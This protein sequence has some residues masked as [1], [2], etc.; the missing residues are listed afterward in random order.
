MILLE[1][2]KNMKKQTMTQAQKKFRK[3]FEIAEDQQGYFTTKQAEKVGYLPTNFTY[4][5]RSG[6]WIKEGWGIYRLRNFPSSQEDH[7]TRLSL[8]SRNR[9]DVPQGVISHLTALS[10]HEISDANPSKVHMTVPNS[11]RRSAETPVELVLFYSDLEPKDV[12]KRLGYKITTPLKTLI[13]V[14]SSGL[15]L[16]H[17]ERGFYDAIGKGLIVPS[18]IRSAEVPKDLRNL[19]EEWLKDRKLSRKASA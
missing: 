6:S 8:W 4:Y 17:V 2:K 5:V 9:E 7:Y 11:F 12:Q 15:S 3:L 16:E 10:L 13:D 19:F 18:E 14:Y 1:S